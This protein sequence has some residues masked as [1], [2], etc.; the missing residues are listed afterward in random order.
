VLDPLGEHTLRF[1][2][3]CNPDKIV[4][5]LRDIFAGREAEL[6]Q[7]DAGVEAFCPRCGARWWISRDAYDAAAPSE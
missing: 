7:D 4:R 2:C 3:G 1:R 5:A 6:F